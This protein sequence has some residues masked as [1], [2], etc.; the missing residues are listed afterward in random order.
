MQRGDGNG[1][2]F[3]RAHNTRREQARPQV[4]DAVHSTLCLP[5]LRAGVS[6]IF[7]TWNVLGN[8][9]C[10]LG[11]SPFWSA[12]EGRLYWVDI[13][14]RAA[15][16][17]A[18]AGGATERWPLPSEPG[19]MA[20]A[21]TAGSPSGWVLALRDGIYRAQHWGGALQRIARLPYDP[22]HERAND[23]KCDP[24][25]RFWVGTRDER[26]GGGHAAMYKR[27]TAPTRPRTASRRATG[28]DLAMPSA[29]RAR[30]T[31]S[32]PSRPAGSRAMAGST[33]A[34]RMAL[35]SMRRATTGALCM[36]AAAWC[37]SRR[38]ARCCRASTPRPY[39]R[40]WCA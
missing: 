11:E 22:A 5:A 7:M 10:D 16:R 14:G 17:I 13:A 36:K 9:I 28:T 20:P 33:V 19:C 39:A 3:N 25:G 38:R 34:A 35:P 32:H 6:R 26:P 4:T 37:S 18:P 15:L 12:N 29:Q 1:Y 24:F 30:C 23:G 40:P 31:S 27:C 8:A 2:F 21:H